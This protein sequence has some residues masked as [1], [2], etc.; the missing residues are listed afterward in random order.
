[1]A[2]PDYDDMFRRLALSLPH[3]NM[4]D[5]ILFP[6]WDVSF[7]LASCRLVR[8]KVAV[9]ALCICNYIYVTSCQLFLGLIFELP[10]FQ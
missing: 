6:T 9:D 8:E 1:M 4:I 3:T 5:R 10:H 7:S 2:Q